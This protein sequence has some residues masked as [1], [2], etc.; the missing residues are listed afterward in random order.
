M[1][2]PHLSRRFGNEKHTEHP[3][4]VLCRKWKESRQRMGPWNDVRIDNETDWIEGASRKVTVIN[5][6][7]GLNGDNDEHFRPKLWLK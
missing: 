4:R 3:Y 7:G 5:V 6:H 2:M 1:R